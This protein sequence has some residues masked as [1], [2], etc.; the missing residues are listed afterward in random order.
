MDND[1]RP[2]LKRIIDYPLVT[3]VV[4]LT[5][6][7][8]FS[9]FAGGILELG[10]KASG[11]EPPKWLSGL[12]AA[13]V[14]LIVYKLIIRHLGER[15]RDDL[16]GP[17]SVRE[18]S[19]GL[20]IGAVLFSAIVGIAA[21]LGVY[22]ITGLGVWAFLGLALINDG[23]VPAVGEELLFRA[24]IFRWT[25]EFAG[26]WI[27]LILS[28]VLFGA[29]HLWNPSATW[30]AAGAIA[31]EAGLLL[32]ASYMLTRRLWMPM[33]IHASWN[34]TQG[35]VYDIPVSGNPAHG[36]LDA[37]LEGPPLLTGAGFGL[38]ASL[39]AI[40]VATLFGCWLLRLAARHGQIMT[41]SWTRRETKLVH[42]EL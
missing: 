11:S 7:I 29:S 42:D 12:L 23:L 21:L 2:L 19:F 9:G 35:E 38:E 40:V 28:A 3:M 31:V 16:S 15:P 13:A 24:I 30:V 33:G 6:L 1:E 39:I 20:L 26:S 17:G 36:L 4:A 41:P 22:R 37:R 8:G 32:G 14:M 25:E 34:V 27:A 10:Y 5:V 18:L